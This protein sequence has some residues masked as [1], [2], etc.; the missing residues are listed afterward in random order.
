MSR[1]C[2][3][4]EMQSAFR[5]I[6]QQWNYRLDSNQTDIRQVLLD[7]KETLLERLRASLLQWHAMKIALILTIEYKS[8]KN[9]TNPSFHMYLRSSV[10]LIYRADEIEV[11]V[12][13]MH[14]ELM[15]RN[16]NIL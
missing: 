14:Q 7:F 3:Q 8:K 4:S 1:N 5:G 2:P 13:A 6:L 11:R 16:E 12:A 9:P 10:A 15:T